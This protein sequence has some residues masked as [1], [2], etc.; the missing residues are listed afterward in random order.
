MTK[1]KKDQ[2]P[3]QPPKPNPALKRLD[4]L[5]GTWKVS[6]PDIDGQVRFEWM[7]GGFFM[8]QHVDLDHGGHKIKGIEYIG[9]DAA[10]KQ[11]KSYFFSNEGPGAFG[12]VALEYVWEVSDDTLTIWGGFVGSPAHFR[13]KFSADGNSNAGRWEWPGGGYE[14]TMTSVK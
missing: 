13:G 3:Q 2:T 9:Y 4:K 5:V 11:L 10:N 7:E 8:M 14:S 1:N 6:G 12:G